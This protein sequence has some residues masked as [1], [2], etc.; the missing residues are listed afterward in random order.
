MKTPINF[1]LHS[2]TLFI[3]LSFF[4]YTYG[5]ENMPLIRFGMIADIQY[6][7]CETANNR[8]YKKSLSKLD[9]SIDYFNKENVDFTINLGDLVD[10]SPADFDPVLIRLNKL[11]SKVYNTTGNH[12]YNKI[13]NNKK[14]YKML[15]MPAQGFYSFKK[16]NWRFVVINTNEIATY[17]NLTSAKMKDELDAMLDYIKKSG[18]K[19]GYTYNGGISNK[20]MN[21]LIKTLKKAEKNKEKVIIFSHHP[22]YPENG[23]TALNDRE[24][25]SLIEHYQC[26]KALF[27]GHHHRGAFAYYKTIPVTT[28]EG[29]VETEN[30]NACGIVELYENKIVL[31][32]HGRMTSREFIINN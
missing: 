5:G 18:R 25:L 20:Q 26:V 29:M 13:A 15:G 2:L 31:R 1:K 4:Q 21:W 12:D 7:D 30:E 16:S 19:N 6:G 3:V 27:A 14:L 32:G 10:R 11:D 9:E 28:V 8:Y 24:I 17:S 22:L 23:L